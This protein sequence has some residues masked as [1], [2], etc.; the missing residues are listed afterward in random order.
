HR[1][2]SYGL[3]PVYHEIESVTESTPRDALPLSEL[4][5]YEVLGGLGAGKSRIPDGNNGYIS[6]T[7]LVTRSVDNRRAVVASFLN[8]PKIEDMCSNRMLNFLNR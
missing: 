5:L 4:G 6:N 2:P 7:T 8:L 3:S 1:P